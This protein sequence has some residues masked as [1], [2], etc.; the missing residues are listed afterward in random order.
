MLSLSAMAHSIPENGD[1]GGGPASQTSRP[2]LNRSLVLAVD[3]PHRL[4]HEAL[5]HGVER[6]AALLRLVHPERARRGR[7]ELHLFLGIARGDLPGRLGV[8]DLVAHPDDPDAG[9]FV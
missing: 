9:R 7:T 6:H 3:V 4:L 5:D 8:D 2:A 1:A